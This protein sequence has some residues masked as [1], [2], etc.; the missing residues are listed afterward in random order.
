LKPQSLRDTTRTTFE[1]EAATVC[2]LRKIA[3]DNVVDAPFGFYLQ[4]SA[5]PE[6]IAGAVQAPLPLFWKRQ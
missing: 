4:H 3:P 2:R 6:R 1:A 5:W